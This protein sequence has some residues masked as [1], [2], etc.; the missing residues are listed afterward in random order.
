MNDYDLIQL[1]KENTS[2]ENINAG[3]YLFEENTSNNSLFYI[4]SGTVFLEKGNNTLFSIGA[5]NII[6]E[7]SFIEESGKPISAKAQDYIEYY[8][9]K[10]SD[11]INFSSEIKLK[12]FKNLSLMLSNRIYKIN[13][14]LDNIK[15]INKKVLNEKFFDNNGFVS[16]FDKIIE[17]DKY[18]LLKYQVNSN[19][20]QNILSNNFFSLDIEDFINSFLENGKEFKIGE[21]YIFM[22]CGEYIYF[23]MGD[24]LLDK[25]ILSNSLFYNIPMFKYLGS[26]IEKNQADKFLE[27]LEQ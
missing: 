27:G 10:H 26:F 13:N 4:E 16:I 17:I 8:E 24:L 11:F 21:N 18:F 9:L 2:L 7:K 1:I 23:I 15:I 25:Y 14:I 19:S 22:K 5:G 6:G 12:F 20:Y 3:N